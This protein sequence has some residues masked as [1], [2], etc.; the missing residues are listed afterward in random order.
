[1]KKIFSLHNIYFALIIRIGILL[2][3]FTLCRILFY[4]FNAAYFSLNFGTFFSVLFYGLRFDI[5]VIVLVNV[6]Y[7]F[8]QVLPFNFRS[9]KTYQFILELIFY[10]TNAVALFLNCIDLVFFRYVFRRTTFDIVKSTFI[11]DDF[12]TMFWKYVSDFWYI[13]LIWVGLIILMI[14]LYKKTKRVL[15]LKNRTLKQHISALL[16]FVF[17]LGFSIVLFRGGFQLRPIS[18][19]TA[20]EYT[21]ADNVPLIINTPFSIYSTAKMQKLSEIN[22]FS[23]QQATNYFDPIK[24]ASKENQPFRKLN[25]VIIIV[26]SLSKEYIGSLNKDLAEKQY[27][28]YTP[29]LDSLI[30][31][32]LCFDQCFANS[33]RSIEGIPCILSG[34]P[35][36]MDDAYLTSVF[37]GN[38]INS[39]PLLL[40]NY[41]YSSLFFHGG[42]NGTLNF[43]AYAKM[44]G[45][46]KYYGKDEYNND[47]DYDGKWGIFDEEFLTYSAKIM[48]NTPNPFISVVYTL[49]SHHPYTIPKKYKGKFNKGALEIHESIMYT[50]YSLKQFFNTCSHF[51]WFDST[52]F[53]ITA[54]HSSINGTEF[55]QNNAGSYAV[56]LIFYMRNSNLS[57][58]NHEI[59]Q[60]TDILPSIL[61]YLNFN[62]KYV[63]FGTSAFD[64]AA[65]HFSVS[66]HN[67]VYQIIKDSFL[68]EFNGQKSLALYN[69]AEDKLLKNDLLYKN[70]NKRT[71]LENFIKAFIQSYN[72]RMI[73]NKL[74]DSNE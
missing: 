53:V 41:G 21:T 47:A 70:N 55:Y 36:L 34:L 24:K 5:S 56:P 12:S 49:S 20:G 23:E 43:D 73:K 54:D 58:I 67:S 3:L 60:Q 37:S 16:V 62:E 42:K 57:G 74:T 1:M 29:F 33:K 8:F 39:L 52:L 31:H 48:N 72:S 9:N 44:A 40:K 25:V 19:V 66:Y 50:D 32:S 14:V 11:G 17:S 35:S 68:L 71:Y 38:K 7:I 45:F 28:G 27:T 30:A 51:S 65:E 2:L 64:S 46:E 6:F 59:S 26:E 22:Y 10:I 63:T 13:F 15:T 69:I 61:D 18:L 4:T